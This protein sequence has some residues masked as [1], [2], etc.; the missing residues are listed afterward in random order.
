MVLIDKQIKWV[1][2]IHYKNRPLQNV[3][4]IY[5]IQKIGLSM[6]SLKC[7]SSDTPTFEMLVYLLRE[8]KKKT[9]GNTWLRIRKL[10][11]LVH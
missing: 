9:L 11:S 4:E 6:W 10:Q 8:T 2:E 3:F 7:H 5:M 1:Q